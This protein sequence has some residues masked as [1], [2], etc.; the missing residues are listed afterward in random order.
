M[1]EHPIAA[2]HRIIETR[3]RDELSRWL[4]DDAVFHS[5]IVHTPQRGKALVLAYLSAA[6]DVLANEH[7]RY[8][9][10]IVGPHDALLEFETTIDGIAVN[11]IDLIRWNDEGRAVDFKVMVRPL[12]GIQIV[13]QRM[14]AR[15][16]SMMGAR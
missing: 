13:H 6:L 8:V 2:W 11:G 3:S 9:R 10:E 16:E 15:L 5:P 14:A 12:K 7:F 1:S 4:A